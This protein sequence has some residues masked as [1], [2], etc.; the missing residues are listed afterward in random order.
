MRSPQARPILRLSKDS[1]RDFD[2]IAS[3]GRA[4]LVRVCSLCVGTTRALHHR[5]KGARPSLHEAFRIHPTHIGTVCAEF[6]F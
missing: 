6:P 4:M 2:P 3:C 5:A 1:H